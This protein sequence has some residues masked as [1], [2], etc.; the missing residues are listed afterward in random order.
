MR[1]VYGDGPFATYRA[2]MAKALGRLKDRSA[3]D[4]L[5]EAAL[6]DPNPSVAETARLAY[7]NVTGQAVEA[8]SLS[9]TEA[10]ANCRKRFN[11]LLL[12]EAL[13]DQGMSV[14]SDQYRPGI[15]WC[16]A[17]CRSRAETFL[18]L[19]E[20]AHR[21]GMIYTYRIGV[22]VCRACQIDGFPP[23][24]MTF[25]RDWR[26]EF[27]NAGFATM[28]TDAS[29]LATAGFASTNMIF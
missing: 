21:S 5:A 28:N 23:A 14:S 4:A 9:Q 1:T 29:W 18:R 2:V 22:P 25:L 16:C 26:I 6:G 20:E 8:I 3:A 10:A 13:A 27:R 24:E 7:S 11:Q 15:V 19:G 17:I 12:I